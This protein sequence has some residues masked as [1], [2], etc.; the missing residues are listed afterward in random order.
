M[1]T[2]HLPNTDLR[3]WRLIWEQF[4]AQI[5]LAAAAKDDS[6]ACFFLVGM[7][8]IYKENAMQVFANEDG[9]RQQEEA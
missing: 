3:A 1:P 8:T 9:R 5:A 2:N 4:G 7:R 6:S